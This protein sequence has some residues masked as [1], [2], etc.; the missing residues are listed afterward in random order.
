M[1]VFSNNTRMWMVD[2]N[3]NEIASVDFPKVGDHTFNIHD[4]AVA[5]E[6]RG[7]GLG[8]ELLEKVYAFLKENKRNALVTCEYA[9][10]WFKDHPEKSD[11]LQK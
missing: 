9:K 6:Y 7:Q 2:D 1:E 10:K 3:R 4:V 11:I 5:P 8:D